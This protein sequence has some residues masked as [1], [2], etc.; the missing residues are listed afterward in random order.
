MTGVPSRKVTERWIVLQSF[1]KLAGRE[2]MPILVVDVLAFK[3]WMLTVYR[4]VF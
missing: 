2:N 1:F 3:S 4:R